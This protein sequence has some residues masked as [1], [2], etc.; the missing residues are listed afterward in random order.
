VIN[1]K[2]TIDGREQSQ[3]YDEEGNKN[4]Q[5]FTLFSHAND[6]TYR[7]DLLRVLDELLDAALDLI[8]YSAEALQFFRI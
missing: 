5:R 8:A 4:D 7:Y 3:Q 6:S 2:A 1:L